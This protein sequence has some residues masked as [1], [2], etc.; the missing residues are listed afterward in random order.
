MMM[1][2]HCWTTSIYNT[3]ILQCDTAGVKKIWFCFSDGLAVR[4]GF[5]TT[6]PLSQTFEILKTVSKVRIR[7]M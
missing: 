5:H 2:I 7:M 4:V 1:T 3:L 6:H